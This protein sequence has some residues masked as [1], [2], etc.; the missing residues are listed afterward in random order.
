[1]VTSLREPVM[2]NDHSNPGTIKKDH[3]RASITG[4]WGAKG[5]TVCV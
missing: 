2:G 3:K 5:E 1:L 4:D